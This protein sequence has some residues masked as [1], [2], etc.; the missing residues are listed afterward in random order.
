MNKKQNKV[1]NIKHVVKNLMGDPSSFPPFHLADP[2]VATLLPP[3]VHY[4][5]DI[6]L[7]PRSS[8]SI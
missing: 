8:T 5:F 6:S 2:E 4:K 7:P 1:K 3:Y